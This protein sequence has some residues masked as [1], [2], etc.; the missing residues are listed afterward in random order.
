[1]VRGMA[2]AMRD[3]LPGI[4]GAMAMVL[5]MQMSYLPL[6]S[7]GMEMMVGLSWVKGIFDGR[8]DG[9]GKEDWVGEWRVAGSYS[10]QLMM[11]LD[12][13]IT[14]SEMHPHSLGHGFLPK[15]R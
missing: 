1:M 8:G 2:A 11:L 15:V 13:S 12:K 5:S 14:D 9:Y 10:L 3:T 7:A 4:S 6:S